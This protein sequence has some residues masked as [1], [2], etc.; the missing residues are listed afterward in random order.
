MP[1][2]MPTSGAVAVQP[3][4][5]IL[6]R[7]SVLALGAL[8]ACG[9]GH[10]SAVQTAAV[11]EDLAQ[12]EDTTPINDGRLH[13]L[14]SPQEKALAARAGKPGF[15]PQGDPNA[16]T[17][18][19]FGPVLP[20]PLMP[21]HQVLLP[22]GRVLFYGS[23]TTGKQGG[24][25]H[26]A[27]WD[28]SLGTGDNAFM[29]L[30]TTT[31]SNIFCAGQSLLP[32]TGNVLIIGGTTINNGLRGIGI[33]DSNVFTPTANTLTAQSPM[34][35]RRWY[36]T[37]V[38]MP[39][40]SQLVM[41]GRM[42]PDSGG[43]AVAKAQRSAPQPDGAALSNA[44]YATTPEVWSSAG[45]WRQLPAADSDEVF[46]SIHQGWYYP[47]AWVMP[48]GKVFILSNSGSMYQLSTA[49]DGVLKK[50][51]PTTGQSK[52][53]LQSVMYQPGKILSI[54][55]NLSTVLIDINGKQPVVT[56][57]SPTSRYREY[58]NATLLADGQ[59]WV[60]GG[61]AD[62]NVDT[63]D[64]FV[65]EIWN[66]ATGQWRD[67]ATATVARLYHS[68]AMLLPDATVVTGGGG[69][70]GPFR[71][72]NA[73]IYYPP[74]L[75]LKDGTG[76]PA[77]RPAITNAPDVLGWAQQFQVSFTSNTPIS[78]VTL[79]RTG[80]VTHDF[81]SNQRFQELS[82]TQS[83]GKLTLKTPMSTGVAPPGY[84][85]LFIF[86]GDGVPSIAK[87]FRIG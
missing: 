37:T 31:G 13:A 65:S 4:R 14:A 77:P 76:T 54:R 80:V 50:L 73:E 74:Y 1:T 53:L 21:I 8:V 85:M 12:P 29:V 25:L 16:Q 2:L 45:G 46:G 22:D 44:T 43:E 84:Y 81:N 75:Y 70:P 38:S 26:Y 86:D 55:L 61:G 57:T 67:M 60:N 5:S 19:T 62:G 69:D 63:N 78:R 40:N 10:D 83:A 48:S 32:D 18:G 17:L 20:W 24:G 39:D 64:W 68:N 27:V 51:T 9:G 56:N 41:G 82:F 7:L 11:E 79:I 30:P 47:R 15:I 23:D 49:G 72:L 6:L 34:N 87:I 35:F 58:G 71:N 59:V 42:D 28:P 36:P 52:P 33:N 3:R 66:P